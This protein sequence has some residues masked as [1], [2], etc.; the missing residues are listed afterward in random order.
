MV[1]YSMQT[2][3]NRLQKN[4]ANPTAAYALVE[5]RAAA[6]YQKYYIK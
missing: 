2:I 5:Q 4:T 3:V 6:S 1:C